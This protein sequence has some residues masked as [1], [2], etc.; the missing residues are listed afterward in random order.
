MTIVDR[1]QAEAVRHLL[2]GCLLCEVRVCIPD[3]DE[4]V[5]YTVD[6]MPV[7][8]IR[9][10]CGRFEANRSAREIVTEPGLSFAASELSFL[11]TISGQIVEE[12]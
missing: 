4:P 1:E 2:V 9:I 7:Q 12:T 10:A 8:T 5:V 6:R 11:I 3:G